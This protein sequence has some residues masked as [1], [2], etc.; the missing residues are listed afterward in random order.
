[1]H[2]HSNAKDFIFWFVW[3]YLLA[4]FLKMYIVTKW[5]D[6]AIG[7]ALGVLG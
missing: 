2:N 3:M 7:K 4:E 1:M 6:S 5:P